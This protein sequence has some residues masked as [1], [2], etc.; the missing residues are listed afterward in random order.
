MLVTLLGTGTSHGVPVLGCNCKTCCSTDRRNHRNRC[1]A[2]ITVNNVHILIDTPP[3]FRLQ[4]LKNKLKQIDLVLLTHQHSDHVC[5][6]DDLRRFN[7]L[8]QGIIPVY[9]SPETVIHMQNMFAY[10][11]NGIEEPGGGKPHLH[12]ESITDKLTFKEIDILPIPLVHGNIQ[13]YGYRIGKFAYVTDF[14][15]MPES[16]I[17]LLKDLDVLVLGVLRFRPHP[18]H[19]N[20]EQGLDLIQKIKPQQTWLTH[21]SHDFNHEELETSLPEGVRIGYDGLRIEV[22]EQ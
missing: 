6:F 19:L 9:G 21:I 11:F 3:E 4:A 14:N 18:T 16:S 22:R 15:L 13:V 8:Q 12:L 7:E 2:Y 1:S 17:D 5:G 10:I 20:L